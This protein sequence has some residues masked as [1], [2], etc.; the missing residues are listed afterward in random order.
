MKALGFI[1]T[2]GLISSIIAADVM[3]KAADVRI[4]EKSQIGAGLVS[5]RITGDV[6]AV[7]A[8]IEAAVAVIEQMGEGFLVSK[9][10]I[11]RP[12]T[13]LEK[14]FNDEKNEIVDIDY[15]E[16]ILEEKNNEDSSFKN[17][18]EKESEDAKGK[19]CFTKNEIDKLF[20][21]KGIE[22]VERLLNEFKVKKLRALII[23]YEEIE[24]KDRAINK[25]KKESIIKEIKKYYGK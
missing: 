4:L 22:E 16:K 10:I 7:K 14:I 5:I 20:Y 6:G 21:E 2:K 25:V 3:V 23:Q 9:N 15:K 17:L 19:G 13:E 11:A 18:E 8:A 24:I 12:S 1:E